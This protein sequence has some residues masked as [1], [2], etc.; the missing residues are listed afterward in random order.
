[1]FPRRN[2]V[3]AQTIETILSRAMSDATFAETLFA[4]PEKALAGY[5]LTADEIANV[6]GMARTDF[7]KFSSAS[8]EERKSMGFQLNHNE[9]VL[10]IR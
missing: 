2:P 9:T 6:K 5:D 3:S 1:M 8:P 10:T 4:N 7:D